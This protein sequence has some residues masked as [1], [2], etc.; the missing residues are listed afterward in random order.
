M[1]ILAIIAATLVPL[2]LGFIWYNPNIGFGRA[3]MNASGMTPEKAKSANMPVLIGVSTLFALFIAFGMQG[4]VVHQS[5]LFSILA[6]Q[7]DFGEAGSRSAELYNTM[8]T[9]FGGSYRTFGHGFFHGLLGGIMIALP[10]VG[11]IA[12][13]EG[14]GFKYIAINAGFWIMSMALMGGIICVFR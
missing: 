7:S 5:H 11:T 6:T 14:K 8:M 12:L 2:V 3:W 13:Y 1:N 9:E 4:I 10:I